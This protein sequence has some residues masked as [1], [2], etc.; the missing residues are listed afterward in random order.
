MN[1]YR[2]HISGDTRAN[3]RIA[4][5]VALELLDKVQPSSQ[6]YYKIEVNSHG[7]RLALVSLTKHTIGSAYYVPKNDASQKVLIHSNQAMND[8]SLGIIVT[9]FLN[10]LAKLEKQ[11]HGH[12]TEEI[13]QPAAGKSSSE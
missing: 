12:P 11:P 6:D 1:D 8:V 9:E 3:L 13:R 7:E 5:S 10:G 2:I 4:S